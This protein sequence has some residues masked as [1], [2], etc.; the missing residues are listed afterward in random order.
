MYFCNLFDLN[1][2][3][4]LKKESLESKWKKNFSKKTKE[5]RY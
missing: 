2:N 1:K 3:F 4:C 5:R